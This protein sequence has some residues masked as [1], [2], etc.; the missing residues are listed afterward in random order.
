MNIFYLS[1]DPVQAAKYQY[2]K[3]VVKMILETAQ[4]LCTAH[5]EL[6]TN[7]DIPYKATHKNH[8]SAIWVRSSAEAY[9]WAYEHMLA[10]GK[11]Y[12]RRYGKE[13]LTIAKCRDVLYTLPNGISDK[14]FEQP[15]QCMPN[16]YKVDGNSVL[17]YWNYYENEKHTVKN[18]NEQKI[19]RP[20]NINELFEH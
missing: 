5:H 8:P 9:M 10:L 13:H 16:E 17:G 12:T 3:H 6:G 18:K 20:H 1:H 2:N 14:A 11:E 7:I 4:L 15:P 19:I